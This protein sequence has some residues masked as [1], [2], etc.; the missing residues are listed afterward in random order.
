[1]GSIMSVELFR[2]ECPNC[3]GNIK[4][5]S[6]KDMCHCDYCDSDFVISINRE[7]TS[8][9]VTMSIASAKKVSESNVAYKQSVYKRQNKNI[10]EPVTVNVDRAEV[11][12][13]IFWRA[14]VIMVTLAM[15]M[16]IIP[17][18]LSGNGQLLGFTV[19]S[20]SFMGIVLTITNVI[21]ILTAVLCGVAITFDIMRLSSYGS[22]IE[23]MQSEWAKRAK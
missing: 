22:V 5:K 10:T 1:M 15:P 19:Q 11:C 18:M 3:G 23:W 13:R 12:H 7:Q 21:F 17:D 14:L 4:L 8:A 20:D 16:V 6:K 2:L 9:N